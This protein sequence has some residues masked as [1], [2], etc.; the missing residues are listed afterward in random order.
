MSDLSE[1]IYVRKADDALGWDI[2]DVADPEGRVESE[3]GV[4][5]EYV[6]ADQPPREVVGDRSERW[7]KVVAMNGQDWVPRREADAL[8]DAAD[9][10]AVAVE[11]SVEPPPT[12][13]AVDSS[14]AMRQSR[15]LHCGAV[16]PY[17]VPEVHD[18]RS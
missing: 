14:E 5:T 7:S 15:C 16:N 6:R 8:A 17:L 13:G 2:L 12:R 4:W 3:P 18:D 1:R 9:I 10:Y 11:A